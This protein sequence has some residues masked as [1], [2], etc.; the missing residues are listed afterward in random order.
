VGDAFQPIWVRVT[1]SATPP[2]PVM[3]ARVTFQSMMF[4]PDAP[5][6]VEGSGDNGSAHYPMKVLL[7]SSETTPLT[8]ANGL[9]M[10]TP[11]TGGLARPLQIEVM[12][13]AGTATPLQYELS[14][15]P[16]L[17]P[18]TGASTGIARR[19]TQAPS[20]YQDA[21]DSQS[22]FSATPRRVTR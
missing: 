16:L 4:L 19:R 9:A 12:A 1:N 11:S 17:S 10:L 15:L 2:N 6:P 8:D 14:V 5:V 22:D 18:A 20:R 7:G 3:G 13:S 21:S